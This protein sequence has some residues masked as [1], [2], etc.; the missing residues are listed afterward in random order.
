MRHNFR[1]T[2][3]ACYIA[4]LTQAL[5]INFTPLLYVTFQTEMGLTLSQN[6]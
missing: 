2:T 6:K 5:V 1:Y 4:Y 3:L